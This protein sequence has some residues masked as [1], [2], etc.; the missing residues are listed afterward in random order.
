M[1]FF[2]VN[3]LPVSRWRNGGGETREIISVPA[4]EGKGL[5][6]EPA[7]PPLR[8]PVTFLPFR[9]LIALLPCWKAQVFLWFFRRF[10]TVCGAASR[11]FLPVK[12]HFPPR[13]S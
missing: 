10:R 4:V 1:P 11:C 7:L 13:R 8:R 2:D 5:P 9:A 6:G 3:T 12:R